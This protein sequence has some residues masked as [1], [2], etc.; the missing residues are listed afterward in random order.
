MTRPLPHQIRS[1]DL[2]RTTGGFAASVTEA[3]ADRAHL[4]LRQHR[5]SRPE[6]GAA[7]QLSGDVVIVEVAAIDA[8]AKL[9]LA[10]IRKRIATRLILITPDPPVEQRIVALMLGTD[11]VVDAAI[12]ERELSAMLVN[13]VRQRPAIAPRTGEEHHRWHIEEH[14]WVLIAPNDTEVP[15]TRSEHAVMDL[16]L[17]NA[18]AIQP[19]AALLAAINGDATRERVLDVLLS[20]LRRKVWDRTQ[21]ELPLRSARNAGYVFA[22]NTHARLVSRP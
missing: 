16:L 22:G 2:V 7:M 21:L 18:G 9:M 8:G 15:L 10:G 4:L 11:H 12:D 1:A 3:A 20:K 19:R 13:A 5:I 17:R 6:A 14:R